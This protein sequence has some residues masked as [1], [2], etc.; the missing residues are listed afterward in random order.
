[1]AYLIL[2]EI[3]YVKLKD[4]KTRTVSLK[5]YEMMWGQMIVGLK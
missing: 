5:E 4:V 1:M 3:L 2:T